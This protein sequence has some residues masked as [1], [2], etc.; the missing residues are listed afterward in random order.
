MLLANRLVAAVALVLAA[1]SG[2]GVTTPAD[3]TAESWQL[4]P[5]PG[6]KL[7]PN[8][9]AAVRMEGDVPVVDVAPERSFSGAKFVF[10]KPF[11]FI[12]CRTLFLYDQAGHRA[13]CARASLPRMPVPQQ[14]STPEMVEATRELARELYPQPARR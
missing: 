8:D 11:A 6:L 2:S 1:M 12:D 10:G 14:L 4:F 13:G 3:S 7:E 9:G 5:A